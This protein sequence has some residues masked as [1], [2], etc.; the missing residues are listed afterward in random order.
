MVNDLIE[1]LRKRGLG[2]RKAVL[3]A[4]RVDG[5][6]QRIAIGASRA[7]RD[8]KHLARMFLLKLDRIEPGLGIEAM[9]IEVPHSEP[10]GALSAGS[11]IGTQ[12]KGTDL[13]PAIDQ[14]VGRAGED[15]VFKIAPNESDVP[16]RAVRRISPLS[17]PGS[18]PQWKRP[19]RLLRPQQLSHVVALLPDQAPRRFTWQ[20]KSYQVVA[21][22]GPERIPG[23]WWRSEH[24]LWAVRDY[25]VVE[26]ENG[27][28]FWVFR[29]GDGV[30]PD[31]GNLSWFIHGVFG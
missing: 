6:T 8:A 12:R 13:A 23:E 17:V 25:F 28:R 24:E 30:E 4:D 29:R 10:L 18:W 27:E 5:Q 22:D 31:T 21:G 2:V 11:L 26:V 14:L 7:T 16:E 9:H 19:A 1:V 15:A 20:G 3:A